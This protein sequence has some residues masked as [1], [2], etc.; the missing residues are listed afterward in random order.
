MTDPVCLAYTAYLNTGIF[1]VGEL[2]GEIATTWTCSIE[3]VNFGGSISPIP[4]ML[5]I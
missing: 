5:T 2:G 3:V 1:F 4:Y